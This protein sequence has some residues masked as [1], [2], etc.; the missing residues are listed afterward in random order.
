ML[1]TSN[2]GTPLSHSVRLP[3]IDIYKCLE[4][5]LLKAAGNSAISISWYELWINFDGSSKRGCKQWM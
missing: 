5:F 3:E 1:H 2:P 4:Y